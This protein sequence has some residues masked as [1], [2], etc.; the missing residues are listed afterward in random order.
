MH[1]GIAAFFLAVA[2]TPI[3]TGNPKAFI[4]DHLGDPF[5]G[6]FLGDIAAGDVLLEPGENDLEGVEV[7]AEEGG[8][9]DAT[10]V[11]GVKDDAGFLVV[12]AVQFPH[13]EHIA[14]FAVFVGFARFED[15]AVGHGDRGF[16]SSFKA[17][18]VSQVGGGG[19]GDFA[20]EFFGVGGDGAEDDEAT[21]AVGGFFEVIQHEVAQ[22]EVA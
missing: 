2:P 4:G 19:D 11:E 21:I 20:A 1:E 22:Q 8:F 12:A 5:P 13:G 3:D 14:Q 16:K 7:V 17:F 6:H 15:F 18:E 10:G 9:G